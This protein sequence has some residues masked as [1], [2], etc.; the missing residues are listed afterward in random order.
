MILNP[1]SRAIIFDDEEDKIEPLIEL[2][3]KHLVPQL[4]ID[5]SKSVEDRDEEK[6]L[7]NIRLVFTDFIKGQVSTS[8]SGQLTDIINAITSTISKE[9]GPFIIV[10][11]SAHAMQLLGSFRK[12]LKSAGYIFEDIVLEK[13]K[14]LHNPN[15]EEMLMDINEKLKSKENFINFLDW[16]NKV[17]ISASN[18]I[19]PFTNLKESKRKE[20]IKN[21]SKAS[22]GSSF[23]SSCKNLLKGFYNTMTNLLYD[24]IEKNI[25]LNKAETIVVEDENE[26]ANDT[27]FINT[28]LMIDKNIQ[29]NDNNYPGNVYSYNDFLQSCNNT[30]SSLHK[31]CGFEIEDLKESIFDRKELENINSDELNMICIEISPYCDHAQKNMK[32]AKLI[33]GFILEEEIEDKTKSKADFIYKSNKFFLKAN[34]SKQVIYLSFRHIFRVSPTFVDSL[35][36]RFRIRKEMVNEIQ[37]QTAYYLSRPGLTTLYEN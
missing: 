23:D 1:Y 26:I 16:E 15:I 8:G 28:K 22:L 2:F 33:T 14:Y 30:N 27:A 13:E 25:S 9:N 37:H 32:K 5:F 17:K 21:L 3:K 19:V 24:E 36:P 10:T 12:E 20:T 18:I 29:T 11:W 6:K 4:F 34:N 35:N 31:I 7:K